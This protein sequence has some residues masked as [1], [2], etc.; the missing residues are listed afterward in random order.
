MTTLNCLNLAKDCI[1]T[2]TAADSQEIQ[3]VYLH[4]VHAKHQLQWSQM[5]KQFQS[6]S[7]VTIR[8]RFTSQEAEDLKIVRP[9]PA[10]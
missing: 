6:V 4:H 8:N 2:L 10:A 1:D 9:S 7:I 5:T 3:K